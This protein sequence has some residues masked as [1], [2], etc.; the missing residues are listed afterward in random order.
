MSKTLK[1]SASILICL[2]VGMI[3]SLITYPA[4]PTWYA[5]L[6]KPIFSPPGW[7]FGPVWTILYILM[8]VSLF[9]VWKKGIKDKKVRLALKFFGIQLFL[10][11]IW[12]PIFFGL[13]NPLFAFMVIILMWFFIRKTIIAFAEID[14]K[15]SRLL[16]PYLVWVSFASVLNFSVWLLN[17]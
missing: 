7:L 8:G 4:I 3:G 6:V 14:K 2:L 17:R 1:L 13:K 5:G 16:Y 15:A 10:N 12:S 11:G 9:M